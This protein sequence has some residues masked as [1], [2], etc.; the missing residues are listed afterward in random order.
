ARRASLWA[1][2]LWRIVATLGKGMTAADA[3]GAF[4][5]A[6]QRSVF[7]HGLDE[8]LGAAR[9]KPT[10]RRHD[11]TQADLI[12]THAGNQQ[13][14]ASGS[15]PRQWVRPHVRRASEVSFRATCFT[16]RG[17]ERCK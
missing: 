5:D 6:A 11:G 17:K 8:I 12:E 15:Q 9:L 1:K 4:P 3:A 13:R 7:A 16:R 10:D 14:R 2:E